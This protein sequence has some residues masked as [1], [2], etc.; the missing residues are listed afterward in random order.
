MRLKRTG[1]TGW[2]NTSLGTSIKP[3]RL[4][5]ETYVYAGF[6]HLAKKCFKNGKVLKLRIG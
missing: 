6:L 2:G 4:G 5:P 3:S 1:R